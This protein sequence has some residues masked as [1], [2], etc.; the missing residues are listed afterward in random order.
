MTR[1][2]NCARSRWPSCSLWGVRQRQRPSVMPRLQAQDPERAEKVRPG[3]T[4]VGHDHR[5]HSVRHEGGQE[6]EEALLESVLAL[7]ELPLAVGG[8]QD[9]HVPAPPGG[10]SRPTPYTGRYRSSP[11]PRRAGRPPSGRLARPRPHTPGGLD[12]FVGQKA[13]DPFGR[14]LYRCIGRKASGRLS[15]IVP[16][17]EPYPSSPQPDRHR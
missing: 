7:V 8:K 5:L 9:R 3:K 17:Q 12:A 10:R 6:L 15:Q 14:M 2:G 1:T 13:V 16:G 4:P 11:P